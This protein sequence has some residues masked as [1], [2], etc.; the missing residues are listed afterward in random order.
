MMRE[1]IAAKRKEGYE[2][3][4]VRNILAPVRGMY[5]QAIEDGEPIPLNPAAR[6]RKKNRG[7]QKTKINPL[8]KEETS[9]FL[10]KTLQ[11]AP[12]KYPL[13]LCAVRTG[14]RRGELIALKAS[15]VNFE[16]RL[17][18]VQRTLSRG[19]I[20]P[21]KSGKTRQV[22]MS[23]Q[24]TK[25]LRELNRKG[26][27]P[28]FQTTTGTMLEPSNLYKAYQSFLKDAG[29]RRIRFHDLR[30]TFATLH[31]INNQSLA[32]IRDQLG[33]S[34]I[35]VTVDLYG[36]L[37]AGYNKTAADMVDDGH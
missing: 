32:Y 20:K 28:L 37:T 12:E 24:L 17:I 8:T 9:L 31:I 26:D 13:Y 22:D 21:P 6:F 19:K 4:T 25:V 35:K 33:H 29:L 7:G 34:S 1:L 2:A 23:A 3:A 30:H 36:H 14:I 27:E 5:N 15:D 11:L 16:T 10:Q 18:N